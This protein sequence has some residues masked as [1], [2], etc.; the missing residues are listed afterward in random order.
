MGG[1]HLREVIG[2]Y[3]TALAGLALI[4][5]FLTFAP[6][7]ALLQK[8][9]VVGD[10][11]CFLQSRGL[12]FEIRSEEGYGFCQG[13]RS[14]AE[15][16]FNAG[17]FATY[18]W[19]TNLWGNAREKFQFPADDGSKLPSEKAVM[20]ITTR[21]GFSRTARQTVASSTYPSARACMW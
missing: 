17:K 20:S 13:A 19:G 16:A 5:F 21:F 3:G 8:F 6:N 1:I 10:I 15:S 7:L 11:P 4:L 14:D 18:A 2:R 12:T 9:R